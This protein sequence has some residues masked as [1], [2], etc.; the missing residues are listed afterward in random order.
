MAAAAA[1]SAAAAQAQLQAEREAL[2]KAEAE[3]EQMRRQQIT[4]LA[5]T[6]K[7]QVQHQPHSRVH[8]LLTHTHT[9]HQT[10]LERAAGDTLVQLARDLRSRKLAADEYLDDLQQRIAMLQRIQADVKAKVGVNLPPSQSM[11]LE[12][13]H[14][15]HTPLHLAQRKQLMNTYSMAADAVRTR[16]SHQLDEVHRRRD[17]AL[18]QPGLR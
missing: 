16:L 3:R 18:A 5:Q 13:A 2:A 14:P 12:H 9:N 17:S 8:T 15:S 6:E 10:Q 4:E 7:A 11:R 1:A